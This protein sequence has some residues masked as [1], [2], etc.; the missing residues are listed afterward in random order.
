MY[1]DSKES[2]I[3]AV[4]KAAETLSQCTTDELFTFFTEFKNMLKAKIE[5]EYASNEDRNR[6]LKEFAMAMDNKN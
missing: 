6:Q 4:K 2:S 5:K 1:G 3:S